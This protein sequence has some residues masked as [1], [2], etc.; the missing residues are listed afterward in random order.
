MTT[1]KIANFTVSPELF[2]QAMCMPDGTEIIGADWD[3]ASRAIRLW[4]ENPALNP[5]KEGEIPPTIFPLISKKED[6][7]QICGFRLEWDFRKDY[8]K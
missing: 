8:R 5:V 2:A 4:V 6:P 1:R 7:E 3:F